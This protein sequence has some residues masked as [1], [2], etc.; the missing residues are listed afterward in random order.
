MRKKLKKSE[1]ITDRPKKAF[2]K[3]LK[4]LFLEGFKNGKQH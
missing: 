2:S 4:I 3:M 1:K